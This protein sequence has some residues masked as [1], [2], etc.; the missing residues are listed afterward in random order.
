MIVSN[1]PILT[2]FCYHLQGWFVAS[3]FLLAVVSFGGVHDSSIYWIRILVLLS[4]PLQIILLFSEER[5]FSDFPFAFWISSFLFFLFL[6]LVYFQYFLGTQVLAGQLV[7]SINPNA[8]HSAL[9]QLLV[10]FV[11]YIVCVKF[12]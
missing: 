8:T 7:G 9:S 12:S 2:K 3:I 4:L 5:Y 1:K 6:G 10:Y 11:F